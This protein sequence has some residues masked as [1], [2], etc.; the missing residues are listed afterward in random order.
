MT[1]RGAAKHFSIPKSTLSHN[2]PNFRHNTLQ[3][4]AGRPTILSR[5]EEQIFVNYC[6]LL[7]K[8][9]FPVD[10]MDL[11][12]FAQRYLNQI[13]KNVRTLK[14]NLP[15]LDWVPNFV[16]RHKDRLSHR[17]DANISSDKATIT[18]AVIEV[19]FWILF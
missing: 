3:K 6:L 4:R 13:G 15:G 2:A 12:V 14:D 16:E 9:G 1:I 17:L 5:E 19:F 10:K 8:W 7:S 18:T 11:R